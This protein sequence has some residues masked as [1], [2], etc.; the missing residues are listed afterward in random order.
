MRAENGRAG[1]ERSDERAW[2]L[3]DNI[4]GKS[5]SEGLLVLSAKSYIINGHDQC[6]H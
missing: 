2:I 3:S 5:D 6:Q 1:E 4:S